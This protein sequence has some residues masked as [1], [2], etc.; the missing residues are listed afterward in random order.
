MNLTDGWDVYRSMRLAALAFPAFCIA[1]FAVPFAI[2]IL[3][4]R[5]YRLGLRL[6]YCIIPLALVSAAHATF[7]D[8]TW[9]D[10]DR[11]LLPIVHPVGYS[12]GTSMYLDGIAEAIEQDLVRAPSTGSD[13]GER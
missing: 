3:L 10:G 6:V 2:Q 12:V 13:E 8:H 9:G 7:R 4:S 11:G 1:L 5:R